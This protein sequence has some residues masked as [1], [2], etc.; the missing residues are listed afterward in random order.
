MLVVVGVR[1]GPNYEGALADPP[2]G[3]WREVLRGDER[4]FDAG[5]PVARVVSEQG[6]AVFERL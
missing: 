5:V 6:V 3:R 4:S 2:G 1:G